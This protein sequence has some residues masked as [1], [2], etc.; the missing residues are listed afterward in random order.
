VGSIPHEGRAT[1]LIP[2]INQHLSTQSKDEPNYIH[3]AGVYRSMIAASI[4]KPR[5]YHNVV[6]VAGGFNAIKNTSV[7]VT[8]EVCPSTLNN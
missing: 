4:L 3:C 7:E 6:D 5:G 2:F 8:D 1:C